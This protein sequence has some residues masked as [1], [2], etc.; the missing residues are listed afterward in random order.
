MLSSRPF[1]AVH[2]GQDALQVLDAFLQAQLL[3]LRQGDDGIAHPAL[4]VR[5]LRIEVGG[6]LVEVLFAQT[7]RQGAQVFTQFAAQLTW[8][9]GVGQGLDVAAMGLK[10]PKGGIE[11]VVEYALHFQRPLEVVINR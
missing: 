6:V 9:A 2:P 8:H 3:L 10:I 1:Q 5:E 11:P 4:Q 7:L